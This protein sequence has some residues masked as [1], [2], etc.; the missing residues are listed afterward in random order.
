M[1]L[2]SDAL[3]PELSDH[4]TYIHTYIHT[5][6]LDPVTRTG[7]LEIWWDREIQTASKVP[8]NRPDLVVWNAKE[9]KCQ[10]MDVC[11][12]LD[13]NVG[14]R[15]ITKRDNYT[16]LVDQMHRL[17]P[18]YNIRI[19]PVVIRALGT[20]PKMLKENLK[21]IGLKNTTISKFVKQAQKL[22]LLGT[23][24]IVKNFQKY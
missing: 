23:L 15:H 5:Y 14:L 19:I 16:P 21:I 11:I 12:P 24:K 22:S 18:G 8:H 13:I 3:P 9:K 4:C 6:I 17:Y 20:I 2:Q 7:P 10:I 1:D